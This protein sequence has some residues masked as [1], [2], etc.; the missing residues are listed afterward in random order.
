M[1]PAFMENTCFVYIEHMNPQSGRRRRSSAMLLLFVFALLSGG[2][3]KSL[4][5]NSAGGGVSFPC[6][7]KL[8]FCYSY[9]S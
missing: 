1:G 4:N 8:S 7:L 5:D 3:T 6:L 9:V 2:L